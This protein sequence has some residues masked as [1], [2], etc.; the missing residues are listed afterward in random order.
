MKL[1]QKVVGCLVRSRRSATVTWCVGFFFSLFLPL[2]LC[3]I[4]NEHPL[5][6]LLKVG[7]LWLTSLIFIIYVFLF[8]PGFVR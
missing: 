1:M 4:L 7:W 6:L 2:Y 3:G 8:I 5:H